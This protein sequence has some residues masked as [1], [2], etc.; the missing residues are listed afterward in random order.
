MEHDIRKD[1]EQQLSDSF[2]AFISEFINTSAESETAETTTPTSETEV[3]T[4]TQ[5]AD[6]TD[7]AVDELLSLLL[8]DETTNQETAQETTESEE[9][10]DSEETDQQDTDNAEDHAETVVDDDRDEETEHDDD[11]FDEESDEENDD[12]WLSSLLGKSREKEETKAK[13]SDS[14]N[15][16]TSKSSTKNTHRS[17]HENT[18]LEEL[19][20]QVESLTQLSQFLLASVQLERWIEETAKSAIQMQEKLA[21]YGIQLTEDEISQAMLRASS[22][23]LQD[24]HAFVKEIR[25]I[26]AKKMAQ[27]IT[28][29]RKIP[30]QPQEAT[31]T[32]REPF[33][34]NQP[35][36]ILERERHSFEEF[37][38]ETLEEIKRKTG[39]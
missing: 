38:L 15:K 18:E 32:R 28:R 4:P 26:V 8:I 7:S 14:S 12:D 20:K 3:T 6:E 37:V 31:I 34:S 36:D 23:A 5:T 13:D 19:R 17:S 35:Q 30:S 29:N 11:V 33:F 9:T 22:R 24:T 1:A 10:Q 27:Q 39:Q 21:Q 2:E 25:P 16:R